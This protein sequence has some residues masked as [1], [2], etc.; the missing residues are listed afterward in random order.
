MRETQIVPEWLTVREVQ[1]LLAIGRT[2]AY[3]LAASG[4]WE[5]IEVGRAL[6][7]SR[8]S[9]RRWI[10]KRRRPARREGMVRA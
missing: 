5:T 9:L 4:T 6:R 3:E 2:K 10:D 7:I 8:E 1:A